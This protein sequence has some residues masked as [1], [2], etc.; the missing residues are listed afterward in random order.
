MQAL[1]EHQLL[2]GLLALSAIILTGRGTAEIARRFHQPEVLGELL[3]GVILG[4]SILG[5]LVPR[6][7]QFMFGESA[8]ALPL[9]LFSWTGAILLLMLAGTEVDLS[10]IRQHRKAGT[11]A[12]IMSIFPSIIIGTALGVFAMHLPV[13]SAVFLGAVLSVTAVSVVAKIFIETAN[14]R[15]DY[16]QVIMA[17]GI[18]SEILVWPIISILSAMSAGKNWLSGAATI[19][20]AI[21]FIT[22]MLTVGQRFT[23]WAMRRIA[24][25]T[26]I[27]YGQLS[28]LLVLGMCSAAI[29]EVA[30]LHALLGAFVFGLLIGRA[31]RT[32]AHLKESLHSL[33]FVVCLR[34]SFL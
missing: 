14:F 22:L 12:A 33:T 17:A 32:R 26:Q 31:P 2:T 3:G 8:I 29:T 11:S 30:G 6:A 34:Q 13:P 19:P 24:D 4:P 18:A 23:N 5:A 9:S 28:L 16:A 21:L 10:I 27:N 1:T 20:Y 7:H 25:V 15:R